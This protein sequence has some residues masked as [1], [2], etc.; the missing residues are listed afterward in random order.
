[1]FA[2]C[3]NKGPWMLGELGIISEFLRHFL[4]EIIPSSADVS[5]GD[6]SNPTSMPI[7]FVDTIH[8]FKCE[9]FISIAFSLCMHIAAHK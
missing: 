4:Q 1:M 7:D 2:H 3:K 8:R 6:K 5:G 9:R